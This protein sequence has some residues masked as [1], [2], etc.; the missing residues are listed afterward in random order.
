V[1]SCYGEQPFVVVMVTNRSFFPTD[2]VV[3]VNSHS[4]FPKE[5][6][7]ERKKMQV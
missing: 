2:M 5:S 4:F 1:N 7:N 6:R 3:M